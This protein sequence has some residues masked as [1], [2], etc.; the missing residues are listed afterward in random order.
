MEATAQ[1]MIERYDAR[2]LTRLS[3]DDDARHDASELANSEILGAALADAKGELKAALSVAGMYSDEQL[4]RLAP[5]SLA[6]AKRV[7]CELALA[8]LY[9][10]RGGESRETTA[11]IRQ[12]AEEYLERLRKGERLFSIVESDAKEKAGQPSLVAPTAVQL[13]NLNGIT[14]RAEVYFG[15]VASRLHVRPYGG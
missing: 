10:R 5:E 11:Q 15:G 2:Q 4:E 12:S 6:L 14:H 13:Q 1:D 8:F 7:M 9:G 3:F